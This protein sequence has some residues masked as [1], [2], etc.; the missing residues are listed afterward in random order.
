MNEK[1]RRIVVKRVKEELKKSEI[2]ETKS[3]EL[4]ELSSNEIIKRYLALKEEVE[5]LQYH[6]KIF[7]NKE[8]VIEHEFN[9]AFISRPKSDKFTPC[10][11][12]IWIY[13]GSYW[14]FHDD[15]DDY[16]FSVEDEHSYNFCY[17]KYF[18]LECGQTV[19]A[20]NW[21]EFENT[22]FVLKDRKNKSE[23]SLRKIYYQLLFNH[24]VDKSKELFIKE[25]NKRSKKLSK[26]PNH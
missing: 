14:E 1:E 4:E 17:N 8:D 24:T 12:D 3:K 6:I 20:P 25:F 15:Y 9:W 16:E 2:L 11:H 19:K 18:C 26:K 13:E 5:K 21:Q 7:D 10:E 22:H 23:Y